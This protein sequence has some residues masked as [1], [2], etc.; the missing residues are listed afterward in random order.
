MLLSSVLPCCITSDYG[1]WPK[2]NF[3]Q[4]RRSPTQAPLQISMQILYLLKGEP[5]FHF[6]HNLTSPVHW[7]RR[8][9]V[10]WV[11]YR[12]SHELCEGAYRD[13][14]ACA[15]FPF[16]WAT[17]LLNICIH[18]WYKLLSPGKHKCDSHIGMRE[19]ARC[20]LTAKLGNQVGGPRDYLPTEQ[21]AVNSLVGHSFWV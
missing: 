14:E 13:A 2:L 3:I 20:G 11:P 12:T 19:R 8:I 16:F 6:S 10:S 9:G 21:L 18:L 17:R 1:P 5:L 4:R 7:N 15:S